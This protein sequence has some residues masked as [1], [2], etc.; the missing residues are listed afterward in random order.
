MIRMKMREEDM[1]EICQPDRSNQLS[2]RSFAAVKQQ[3]VAST[4][5]DQRGDTTRRCRSRGG[6]AGKNYVHIHETT[7]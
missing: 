3:C 5:H 6:S 7:L 1:F 4:T 2:L